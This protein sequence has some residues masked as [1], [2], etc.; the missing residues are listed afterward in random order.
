MSFPDR[1]MPVAAVIFA[2]CLPLA[3]N[4]APVALVALALSAIWP[5]TSSRSVRKLRPTGPLL[6]MGI[7]YLLHLI[8][9]IWTTNM[10]F[11][12][13][14]LGIKAPLLVFP[15][16]YLF[17]RPL[18]N[19]F[20]VQ[21][22]FVG[23]NAVALVFCVLR[24][25]Y[26]LVTNLI[27][28]HG[29]PGPSM[30]GFA[31][32]VPF[33]SSDL[34]FFLHPTYMAMYLTLA[35]L[36]LLRYEVH[37][38]W[39]KRLSGVIGF[40]LLLGIV[41]CASKAGWAL[42]FVAGIGL[43]AERWHDRAMRRMVMWGLLAALTAGVALYAGTDYVHERVDQVVHTFREDAPSDQA[44]NSTDDRRLVWKAA[45]ELVALHPLLGSGTGDVKDELLRVYAERGYVEPLRKQLN[46]HDQ[47]LNTA[48][49]LGIGTALILLLMILVPTVSAFRKRDLIMAYFLLLNA[50]NWTVE[51]ML[52]V[53][54]GVLFFAFF[55]WLLAM[56]G[57]PSSP[58][59]TSSAP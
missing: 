41:L 40:L 23:A 47:Y 46:A 48:V 19:T 33:F 55:A 8:G 44:A 5:G 28:T 29:Q 30:S 50:L 22:W 34:S 42:L 31:M 25:C 17:G 2:V 12:G 52:E 18:A 21:R 39:P 10:D 43:L 36:L 37:G 26:T 4:I 6:W 24:A 53:Q 9:L 27:N 54:A 51:S 38:P 16:I 1:A 59:R 20:Q 57:S 56:K 32:S 45:T 15:L 58:P 13:L 11:A 49:A 3:P 7:L 35:L 14:D